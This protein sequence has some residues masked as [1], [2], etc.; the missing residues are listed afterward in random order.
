[1]ALLG[2]TWFNLA[3][4]GGTW[5]YL[6]LR[7]LY[8][9]ITWRYVTDTANFYEGLNL[10]MYMVLRGSYNGGVYGA[11]QALQ[12]GAPN[13]DRNGQ[14]A[15]IILFIFSLSKIDQNKTNIINFEEKNREIFYPRVILTTRSWY[16]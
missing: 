1:M 16:N 10:R 8:L 15:I 2:V 11:E 14:T 5:R 6:A 4:C 3:L 12:D 13:V 7:G 9:I